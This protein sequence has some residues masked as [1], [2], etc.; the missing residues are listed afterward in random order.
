MALALRLPKRVELTSD[1]QLLIDGELFKWPIEEDGT[2]ISPGK[3][4]DVSRLTLTV[5]L[6][7]S[8]AIIVDPQDC[9]DGG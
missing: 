2:T 4:K 1:R 3:L 7:P 8:C 9:P 5:L 6:D